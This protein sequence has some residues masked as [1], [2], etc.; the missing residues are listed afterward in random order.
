LKQSGDTINAV[1]DFA[2]NVV[3]LAY[4]HNGTSTPAYNNALTKLNMT[5]LF[6]FVDGTQEYDTE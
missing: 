1:Y 2:A 3:Y 6:S 4:S 5:Q